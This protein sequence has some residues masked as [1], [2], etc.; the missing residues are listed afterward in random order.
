MRSPP[1]DTLGAPFWF[2]LGDFTA[3]AAARGLAE[4]HR[5]FMAPPTGA[6]GAAGTVPSFWRVGF[7][8]LP[9]GV[10]GG[11]LALAER[12]LGVTLTDRRVLTG[13][14]FTTD[15]APGQTAVSGAAVTWQPSAAPF[16]LRGGWMSER[17]SVLGSTG[18]GAFGTLAGEI[19]FAGAAAEAA[20][21]EWR[22]HAGAELGTVRAVSHGGIVSAVSPLT[23]SAFSGRGE[24]AVR[25]R[26]Y[27]P[28]LG[29]ATIAG[30]RRGRAA[31]AVPS[32]RTK[33]GGVVH[34][35]V[36]AD[37]APSGRQI[38]VTAEWDQPL[39]IGELRVG[40]VVTHQ[41]GHRAT[42]APKFLALGGWRWRY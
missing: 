9:P 2:D 1:F 33:A 3:T 28:L 10:E 36:T 41:P 11:H 27:A 20:L 6:P 25:Q 35:S 42:A 16:G 37:L 29:D 12:A 21:G 39:A 40:A 14:A 31:L 8:E 18:A 34:S 4:K 13:T 22:V 17:E 26:R 15:G 38:D 23:T 19:A 7:R 32:G 24:P 5:A 30:R